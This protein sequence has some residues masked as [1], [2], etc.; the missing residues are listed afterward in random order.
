M[1]NNS[2]ME[3]IN[4][5]GASAQ[6]DMKKTKVL[7]SLTIAQAILESGWGKS[8]LATVGK[9]LFGIK[10]GTSWNGKVYNSKTKECYDGSTFVTVDASFRA[11]NNWEESINDHSAFLC[12]NSRYKAVIG[13]TDYKKLVKL[14]MPP[15][16]LLTRHTLTN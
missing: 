10:A 8:S 14:F 2:Q 3:F 12:A 6:K 4:Q 16:M 13:E 7:A 9:A 5:I 15:D 1:A 11:Y